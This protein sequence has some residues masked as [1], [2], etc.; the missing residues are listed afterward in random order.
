MVVEQQK[1]LYS[2]DEE[3]EKS[4]FD[5]QK[6]FTLF[7]LNWK[8]FVLSLIICIGASYLYLRYSTPV[9]STVAKLLVKDDGDNGRRGRLSEMANLG[10]I[11]NNYGLENEMEI[12]QT[13]TL[14]AEAVRDLKLYVSYWNKGRFKN[15]I[16]YKDQAVNVDMDPAHVEKLNQPVNMTIKRDGD[17]Y[18]IEG[19]YF[20]SLGENM[21]SGPYEINTT[22]KMLPAT[23]RTKAGTIYLTRNATRVMND[24]DEE[25]VSI[26][27]PMAMAGKYSGSLAVSQ[28]SASSSTLNLQLNDQNIQRG[29]DYLSQ[30]AICY[31]RQA[32]EDKNEIARRTEAFVNERLEKINAELSTTE[33]DRKSV[34]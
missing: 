29:I 23:I 34:V 11:S 17:S 26:C 33:G 14:A 28:T 32:N 21:S 2:I 9:Y 22:V 13:R 1:N 18:V 8:W 15:N 4:S 6:I 7:L 31:N 25:I 5:F 10:I 20:V 27:S 24:G 16:L 12:L 30:L 3:N 19:T